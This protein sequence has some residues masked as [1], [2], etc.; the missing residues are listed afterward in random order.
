MTLAL[1]AVAD[2]APPDG[3]ASTWQQRGKVVITPSIVEAFLLVCVLHSANDALLT[4]HG[5]P[6]AVDFL[7]GLVAVVGHQLFHRPARD[8]DLPPR[9]P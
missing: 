5:V 4:V 9:Q 6:V 3:D 8:L 1:L 2:A 7:H